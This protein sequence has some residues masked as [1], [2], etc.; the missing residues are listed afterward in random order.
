[1]NIMSDDSK[2]VLI[3]TLLGFICVFNGQGITI[4]L[5][6]ISS[7]LHISSVFANWISLAFFICGAATGLSCDRSSILYSCFF[8]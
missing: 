2:A 1:M 4:A 7:S 6:Y 8:N 5:P 3:A